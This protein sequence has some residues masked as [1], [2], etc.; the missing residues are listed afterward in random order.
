MAENLNPDAPGCL[1]TMDLEGLEKFVSEKEGALNVIEQLRGGVKG[2]WTYDQIRNFVFALIKPERNRVFQT[3]KIPAISTQIA[4]EP[5]AFTVFRARRLESSGEWFKSTNDLGSRAEA[6]TIHFG[7]CHKPGAPVFYGSLFS[8]TVLSEIEVELGDQIVISEFQI[9]Q[10]IVAL[11]VGELDY[12]RRSKQTYLGAEIEESSKPFEDALE[13][14]DSN[15]IPLLVDAFLADE[16]IAPAKS[17]TDYKI[18]SAFADIVFNEFKE[19]AEVEAIV[20]PSVAFRG[21]VNFAIRPETEKK[22][23]KLIDAQIVEITEALGYGI[24]G[25]RKL[26]KLKSIANGQLE[27]QKID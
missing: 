20:F 24:F 22:K 7:R 19:N 9:E 14:I 2:R 1:F 25:H 15:V 21:G 6:E 27:W 13:A 11:P 3:Y 23:M 26:G 17:N 5:V 18:T 16:F 12:F 10:D 4:T 8:E